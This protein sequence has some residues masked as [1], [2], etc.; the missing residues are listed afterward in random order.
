MTQIE[1]PFIAWW[2]QANAEMEDR[3]AHEMGFRDARYWFE[4]NYSPD[5]AARLQLEN[6][7]SAQEERSYYDQ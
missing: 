5:T 2:R 6:E 1:I 3:G 7:D 4:R